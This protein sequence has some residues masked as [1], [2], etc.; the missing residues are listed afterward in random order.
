MNNGIT[1]VATISL[2]MLCFTFG[3]VGFFRYGFSQINDKNSI[4]ATAE[5]VG[6]REY[7]EADKWNHYYDDYTENE[8][9]RRPV[10]KMDIDG[11]SIIIDAAISNYDLTS[12]DIGRTLNVKYRRGFALI[13]VIDDEISI[14]Y[15][16]KLQKT[17]FITFESIAAV[18]FILTIFAWKF[19][20]N[21]FTV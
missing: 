17:L 13:V 14:H 21:I 9:G 8:K 16:N 10:L 1:L 15:Y 18:L 5:L 7:F 2:A 3:C 20:P 11:E 19:L 4:R 6:F 12:D